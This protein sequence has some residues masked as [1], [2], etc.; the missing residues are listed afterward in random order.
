MFLKCLAGNWPEQR[1]KDDIQYV[2]SEC[3]STEHTALVAGWSLTY[4]ELEE[5][6]PQHCQVG[7]L[8][9]N[10]RSIRIMYISIFTF[11]QRF[12]NI[13]TYPTKNV[14]LIF[15]CVYVWL[16][17]VCMYVCM[18]TRFCRRFREHCLTDLSY[19]KH[20]RFLL[21]RSRAD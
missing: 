7:I 21:M 11:L 10:W 13:L 8:P 17:V 16:H 14:Y 12:L 6:T 1:W 3:I 5:S 2:I 20:I 15:V 4:E 9:V 19:S 18:D